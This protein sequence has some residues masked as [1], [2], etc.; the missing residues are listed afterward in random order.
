APP[1]L[2]LL[3]PFRGRSGDHLRL[4]VRDYVE[5]LAWVSGLHD[6][7]TLVVDALLR[8]RGD[9][10]QVKLRA[11]LEQRDP[12]EEVDHGASCG[13]H[14]VMVAV[15]GRGR[16]GGGGGRGRPGALGWGR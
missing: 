14:A 12:S 2:G 13:G 4:P 1:E 3:L 10:G 5:G 15:V 16:K 7:L 11:A 9:A 8:R 6:H